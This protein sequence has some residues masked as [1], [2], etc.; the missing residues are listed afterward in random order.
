M[1]EKIHI[2]FAHLVE[3]ILPLYAHGR[4]FHPLAVLPVAAR[5]G[6]FAKIYFGIEVGGKGIA[7]VAAVAVEYVYGVDFVELMLLSICA[8]CLSYAWVE[9]AAEERDKSSLFELFPVC[10][11]PRV[12]E[13]CRKALFLAPLFID[14]SPLGVV[15]VLG[16]VVCRIQI[17]DAA[18]KAGV[19]YG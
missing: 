2:L 13:V 14:F 8:V 3:V 9:A 10:P 11:L 18:G 4:Y 6:H 17:V 19:H 7:V 5:C 1:V 12:V 16:L 15:G